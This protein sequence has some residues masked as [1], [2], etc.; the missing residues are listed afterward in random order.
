MKGSFFF[1]FVPIFA[2]EVSPLNM[3][4]DDL[5]KLIARFAYERVKLDK[6][7]SNICISTNKFIL[8]LYY[9]ITSCDSYY[10]L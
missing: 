1:L 8:K 3:Y 10:T 6:K 9:T 5:P 2:P 4:S 7:N